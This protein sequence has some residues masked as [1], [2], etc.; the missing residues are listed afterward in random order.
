MEGIPTIEP[1]FGLEAIWI[2][3]NHKQKAELNG[4]TVVD[5]STVLIT[6]LSEVLKE[7]AHFLLEREDTQKLID[8]VKERNPTLV[9]ELLPDLVSVGIIQRVLQNLLVERI[10]IKNLTLILETIADYASLTKNPDDLS[11]QVRRRMGG[12][13]IP[14]YEGEPGIIKAL[15]LDSKLEQALISR[16]K[17]SHFEL[18]LVI[19]PSFT[20]SIIENLSQKLNYLIEHNLE[21]ILITTAELRLAFKR[22]FEPSFPRM[23]VI[24]YQELPK[25]IQIQSMGMLRVAL[26]EET[27]LQPSLV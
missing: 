14:Q 6:H 15:T 18:S 16:V 4:Y 21:P 7:Q 25:H 27:Q 1:V 3:E 19:D 17:R 26:P 8:T 9:S 20:L 5:A 12:F 22:F 10:A 13:F 2:E 11:E 23:H 24:A